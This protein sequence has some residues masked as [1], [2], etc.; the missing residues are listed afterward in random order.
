MKCI[1]SLEAGLIKIRMAVAK[2]HDLGFGFVKAVVLAAILS[3]SGLQAATIYLAEDG[4]NGVNGGTVRE[5]G[6]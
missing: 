4:K 1:E 5:K 2:H 6:I 3:P